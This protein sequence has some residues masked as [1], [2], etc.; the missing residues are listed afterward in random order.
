MSNFEISTFATNS[1]IQENKNTIIHNDDCQCQNELLY[2]ESFGYEYEF[3][4]DYCAK[5]SEEIL[6]KNKI[7]LDELASSDD[8]SDNE[9][10][11]EDED[12]DNESDNESDNEDEDL[13]NESDNESDN[14]DESDN[15]NEDLDTTC[16]NDYDSEDLHNH[17]NR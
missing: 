13:D 10:D 6:N 3:D 17:Y 9:S 11:N 12:L 8:E 14:K 7:S 15:D 4:P 1:D 2:L 5:Y 16:H